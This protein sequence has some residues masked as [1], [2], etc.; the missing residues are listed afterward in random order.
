MNSRVSRLILDS[1]AIIAVIYDEPGS[2]NVRETLASPP[3]NGLVLHGINAF[4]VASALTRRDPIPETEAC[5]LAIPKNVDL[6]LDIYPST[7]QRAVAIKTRCRNLSL[8]DC[9]CLA[10]AEDIGAAILTG[11]RLFQEAG[12]LANILLFR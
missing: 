8:G 12:S 9:F 6:V 1:S 5:R 4:E 11:D 10:F 2:D 7:W 3:P